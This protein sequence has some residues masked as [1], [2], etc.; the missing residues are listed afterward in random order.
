MRNISFLLTAFIAVF[1]FSCENEYENI[2]PEIATQEI[3]FKV[4]G[5]SQSFKALPSNNYYSSYGR[6]D[7]AFQ[8]NPELPTSNTLRMIRS[9]S[10]GNTTITISA[11]NV[12]VEKVAQGFKYAGQGETAATIVI[13][14]TEMSGSIY[15]PHYEGSESLTYEGFVAFDAI[16]G[17]GNLKGTFFSSKRLDDN[18]KL[19]EGNVNVQLSVQER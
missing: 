9:S 1:L 17:D 2:Y 7:N 12:P 13:E 10:D 5:T 16:D 19:E 3:S 14:S 18:P 11:E 6:Y 4:D 15:C 8:Y